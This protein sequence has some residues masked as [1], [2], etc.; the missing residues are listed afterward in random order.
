MDLE[1]NA[2]AIV[3]PRAVCPI[4]VVGASAGG[5]EALRG[6]FGVMPP[7]TG[8]A[9][10]VVQ[11]RSAGHESLLVDL[12]SRVTSL[13]VLEGADGMAL[14]PNHVVLAPA[15]HLPRIEGGKLRLSPPPDRPA[16]NLPIDSAFRSLAADR[17]ELGIAIVLSG[18]GGDGAVGARM[19]NEAGGLVIAQEPGSAGMASMPETAIDSGA[20][21]LVLDVDDIATALIEFVHHPYLRQP[22][23]TKGLTGERDK[24]LDQI[25]ALLLARTHISFRDYKR[26]TMTRRIERRMGIQR[27]ATLPKYL[28]FLQTHA[29]EPAALVQ[30]LLIS[31][32]RFFRDADA[33]QALRDVVIAPLVRGRRRGQP[34]RVWV[35]ACATGEE[36]YSI[37]MLLLDAGA[38]GD[39]GPE[40]RIFA[41]DI[42]EHALD[43]ARVGRY[44]DAAL[45]DLPAGFA[46][47]Y[48]Q[49]Q[50]G[51]AQVLEAVRNCIVF[52]RQD[53]LNDP[54][55]SQ[56]DL[57][58]CRNLLI[59][60]EAEAQKRVISLFH[61]AL[62]EGGCL[63]LGGAETT[64]GRGDLFEPV[65][66]KHRIFRR[67]GVPRA[68]PS[69][70]GM[71]GPA[72]L[73]L[74]SRVNVAP[75]DGRRSGPE[76]MRHALLAEFV[77][78]A[79]LVNRRGQIL[80]VH[81]HVGDWLQIPTGE[82]RAEIL[83]MVSGD[84]RVQLREGL[85]Q[86]ETTGQKVVLS[87]VTSGRL[88]AG[89]SVRVV[90]LPLQG[91]RRLAE[92]CFVV[93]FE[94]E[95]EAGPTP[96]VPMDQ[97]PL[98]ARL[99][100]ELEV[101]RADLESTIQELESANEA[102]LT[103]NEEITT[104]NE[105]MQSTNEELE[106]SK[107]ELQS[108]NEELSTVNVQLQEKIEELEATGNDL[109]NLLNSTAIPT[110]FLDS[111]RRIR[112]FTPAAVKHFTL[113]AGDVG[114]PITD[115]SR[116]FDDPC[117]LADIDKV[118]QALVP[119]EAQVTG[120]DGSILV[121]RI[122]PYRTQQNR[123]EGVVITFTDVTLTMRASSQMVARARQ[124][125]I[126]AELGQRALA[127]GCPTS[128]MREAVELIA[129]NLE[130]DSAGIF[131]TGPD[132]QMNV[133]AAVGPLA[134]A[135]PGEPPPGL[136]L[137]I[138]PLSDLAQAATT[139]LPVRVRA[140]AEQP[141][142]RPPAPLMGLAQSGLTI[143]FPGLP[144]RL[145]ALHDRRPDRFGDDDQ[146]FLQS[147]ANVLGLALERHR[148]E[149]E[150]LA[151]RDLT[152]DMIDTQRL[153]ALLLDDAGK[154]ISAN[155]A[156]HRMF[157]TDP[158]AVRG[159]RPADVSPD[160]WNDP[161]VATAIATV[162]HTG[163]SVLGLEF[164]RLFGEDR[165][166]FQID[167]QRL[168][169]TPDLVIITLDDVTGA[170]QA[171]AELL[172]A[173]RAA[174]H[175]SASKTRFLAAASHDLRQP[176][177]GAVLFQAMAR[178]QNKDQAL[179]PLLDT[180]GDTLGVL[181]DMMDTLLDISRLDAGIIE[182][183]I[184]P[185]V[186]DD[187]LGRL[188][189]EFGPQMAA[190][191]LRLRFVKSGL[192]GMSDPKLLDRILRNLIAN[193]HRYTQTGGVLIGARS[194]GDQVRIQVWDT[195]SGIP[196]EQLNSIFEEFHQVDNEARVRERGLGLGL[197]IVRRLSQ[198]LGHHV[199]VRSKFG[200]GSLFEVILPKSKGPHPSASTQPG[201]HG[202][203]VPSTSRP[204]IIVVEDDPI[205]LQA[206]M[207]ALE[208]ADCEVIG[209]ADGKAAL[210]AFRKG[211]FPRADYIISDYRL[212]GPLN[213]IE[214][215]RMLR[216]RL[217]AGGSGILL[218]GDTSPERLKEAKTS[219]LHLLHKP[220][221]MAELLAAV[222]LKPC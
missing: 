123:I 188:A 98:V 31:V 187:V 152:R 136:R 110:V 90:I 139:R 26:R 167:I 203:A 43:I 205:V 121:R 144:L 87:G 101:T 112:R 166:H 44:P 85:R 45:A 160:L 102:L 118:L 16:A 127:G 96:P 213:G 128:L 178:Q 22:R 117:L 115:I 218:T 100:R 39:E 174:E 147:V 14:E 9:F 99:E 97:Q 173:K 66:A 151:A 220:I 122:L 159:R 88:G 67:I 40:I 212:P 214:T 162:Q 92:P 126:V 54:P 93:V 35:P 185:V 148:A 37:A 64:S 109:M 200:K 111:G 133:L 21:D 78:A 114:R 11:H 146:H 194:A 94:P 52:A 24:L 182:P 30:D 51:R 25:I 186:L 13:P 210:A 149:A 103:A 199:A 192:H 134:P 7:D 53:L 183:H 46:D 108:L 131:E 38:G 201:Y 143:P 74:P 135:L 204:I 91:G 150:T 23:P 12:M 145:L 84:L 211:G 95:G 141:G 105:E 116:H 57:I 50:E 62:G 47:R 68:R 154:I 75:V 209:A 202:I 175:A 69:P 163:R 55:F 219:G 34:I 106:T 42:D 4:A 181:Q 157:S 60:A 86:S 165:R 63:F 142:V 215:I 158:E 208:C 33:F 129:A 120:N 155:A 76:L 222:G 83:A 6:V 5:L 156:Y 48:F 184:Q 56:L 140:Y 20:V 137:D 10:L 168:E 3:E 170:R 180:L 191:G 29:D 176:L 217:G 27:I 196:P 15:G 195:G 107:E 58:S 1:T 207:L 72:P 171:A 49:R 104:I 169:R 177:Q 61:F 189:T 193:A 132:Q 71:L 2:P 65:S 59:Y 77:P 153:P 8:I 89:R 113:I 19:V 82:P 198:L 206:M 18:S 221:M 124:Q 41:S 130:A 190:S 17:G 172:I 80:F 216:E 28:E 73:V 179:S 164:D 125:T 79:V 119:A 138:D 36:A 161:D 197:A 70:S 81:G 32:T